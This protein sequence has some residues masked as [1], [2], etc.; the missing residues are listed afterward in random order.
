MNDP[1]LQQDGTYPLCELTGPAIQIAQCTTSNTM[2]TTDTL[3]L[4]AYSLGMSV[5]QLFFKFAAQRTRAQLGPYGFFVSLFSNGYFLVAL[6]LYALLTLAWV[7]VLMRVP[8]SR[9]YPYVV[10]AFVF[11]PALAALF[12]DERLDSWYFAG[13]ALVI[14]GLTLLLWRSA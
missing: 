14:L 13:T 12:A 11:T 4:V 10:L 9:A 6:T 3:V 5:G 8:L 7:W 1:P 2:S